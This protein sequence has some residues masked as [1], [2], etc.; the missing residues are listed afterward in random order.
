MFQI[1][2]VGRDAGNEVMRPGDS[3][4]RLEFSPHLLTSGVF[5]LAEGSTPCYPTATVPPLH[6]LARSS[7]DKTGK[8]V[9]MY[10][11]V[12]PRGEGRVVVDCAYTKLFEKKEGTDEPYEGAFRHLSFRTTSTALHISQ[13]LAAQALSATSTT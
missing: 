11:D 1:E 5:F 10:Q 13:T 6:C 12:G 4:K 3:S 2:L 7:A 8:P 9:I